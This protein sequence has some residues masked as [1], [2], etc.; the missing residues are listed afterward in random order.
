MKR[1][2]R[3][4][5][6]MASLALDPV[7][8][9]RANARAC[10]NVRTS[11]PRR[12]EGIVSQSLYKKLADLAT[13]GLGIRP[14]QFIEIRG[15]IAM[16]DC[17]EAV[18]LAVERTEAIPCL[19]VTSIAH[20]VE[21]IRTLPLEWLRR[22]SPFLSDIASRVDAVIVVQRDRSPLIETCTTERLKAWNEA[23]GVLV[24]QQESRHVPYCLIAHP[25]AVR[26]EDALLSRRG[27]LQDN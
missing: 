6:R 23:I 27:D 3:D 19:N 13:A 17:I 25:D 14:S 20:E 10:F 4:N 5:P 8:L 9:E 24:N 7:G 26:Q 1:R 18:S 16:W 21:R 11:S 22:P 2:L 15:D 12:R